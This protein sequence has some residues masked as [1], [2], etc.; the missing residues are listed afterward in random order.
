MKTLKSQIN[1]KITN[2]TSLS[3]NVDILGVIPNSNFA[4]NSNILYNFDMS[5]VS[6]LS[7]NSVN[8]TYTSTSSPTP[9]TTSVSVVTSNIQGVVD[10]LNT[11]GIGIF[12]YSGTTIYV[13]SSIYVYTNITIYTLPFISS[14]NTSNVSGG[15]SASNQIQLPLVSTGN[16]NFIVYWG[17]GTSDTITTWNQAETLHTYATS[18]TYTITLQG[19]IEGF[20][21]GLAGD[22]EKILTISNFGDIIL[23]D[24]LAGNFSGCINLDLTSVQDTPNLSTMTRVDGMFQG[25]TFTT[26]NN[27]EDWDV[28]N[29]VEF[30]SMFRDCGRFNQDISSWNL[31]SANSLVR[32]FLGASTFNQPLNTWNVSNVTTMDGMFSGAIVFN[33]PLNTWN[34]SNVVDM[35]NMFA[36]ANNFNQNIGSWNISNVND[37]ANFMLGKTNL[38]YSSTNLNSIYNNWS[39]LSV[40]PNLTI[41]FGTIKYTAGGSAGRL[42]LTSAPNNWTIT[43]GG[44]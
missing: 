33:Q 41:N 9:I 2:N 7:V 28:S 39:L 25:C 44:I 26:I 36:N 22:C 35:S 15:S 21:F 3:Q 37:F 42:I 1:L 11:L 27:L 16:Y 32:M 23:G 20:V 31:A 12:N 10:A 18:G 30:E 14:W 38:N 29:I 17:D 19:T 13:S 43:D 4:N 5:S 8:I 34:V 24:T 40:Q 6:F